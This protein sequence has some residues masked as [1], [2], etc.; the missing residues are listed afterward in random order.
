MKLLRIWFVHSDKQ[1]YGPYT[2]EEIM[3]MLMEGTIKYTDYAFR[4]GFANWEF[5]RNI[6]DFDRRLINPG[7]DQPN[8]NSPQQITPSFKE[9]VDSDLWFLHDGTSQIGPISTETIK[10]GLKN[11]TY[12]W[13][14]YVWQQ[15]M[16]NWTEIRQCKEF[17]RRKTPRDQSL[18][19]DFSVTTDIDDIKQVALKHEDELLEDNYPNEN[20]K[21]DDNKT[22][23]Y[24]NEI[25]GKINIID[26]DGFKNKY[27][28]KS[29]FS[30]LIII[31]VLFGGISLYPKFVQF[32]REREAQKLYVKAIEL[33]EIKKYEEGF[34]TLFNIIDLYPDTDTKRKV[35]NYLRS[36]EPLIKSSLAEEAK[37]I[38]TLMLLFV[39]KYE[40]VPANAIDISYIPDFWLKYFGEVYYKSDTVKNIHVMVYGVKRP[41]EGYLYSLNGKGEE[42]ESEIKMSDFQSKRQDYIKLEYTG[43]K[44]PVTIK[45]K[46]KPVKKVVP[47]KEK[48]EVFDEAPV[49]I[50]KEN[51]EP[52]DENEDTEL[53]DIEEEPEVEEEP[54][55][56]NEQ[57]NE[58]ENI[59]EPSPP[60]G[61]EYGDLID[62][63]KKDGQ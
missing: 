51:I 42:V 49:G 19:D 36:K 22:Y 4:E 44:T 12:F 33:V 61:D 21:L 17:D 55:Q 43:A 57:E 27:P 15:G 47:V 46:P 62:A 63:I 28:L 58:E 45:E 53:E 50:P 5:I 40:I 26:N 60:S 48:A 31:L 1:T 30:I 29:I 35:Q 38:R 37:R 3:S 16:E 20:I 2:L 24:Q 14:Y 6:P 52:E 25:E 39:E 11:K 23:E 32:L 54:E 8:V 7:G 34:E 10:E 41:V 56:E 18:P 59:E 9:E 13:T